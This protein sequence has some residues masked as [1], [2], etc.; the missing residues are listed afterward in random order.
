MRTVRRDFF[1]VMTLL[2]ILAVLTLIVAAIIYMLFEGQTLVPA[3]AMGDF[4]LLA[5]LA[6]ATSAFSLLGGS[7]AA[8]GFY[9]YQKCLD[10]EQSSEK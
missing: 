5:A 10:L 3:I 9:S 2:S 1:L 7:I 8:V 4:K 6:K